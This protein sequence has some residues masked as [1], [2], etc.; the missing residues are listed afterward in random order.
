MPSG[1]RRRPRSPRVLDVLR[2]HKLMVGLVTLVLA[3]DLALLYRLL[4]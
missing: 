3:W 4:M 2:R 1:F